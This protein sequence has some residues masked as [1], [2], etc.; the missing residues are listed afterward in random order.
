MT[1]Q[2]LKILFCEIQGII[3]QTFKIQYKYLTI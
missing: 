2:T 3:K 1:R